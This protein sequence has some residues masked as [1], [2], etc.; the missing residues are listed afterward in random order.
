MAMVSAW[1][2]QQIDGMV[3]NFQ[4]FL[5]IDQRIQSAWRFPRR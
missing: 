2:V 4:S 3:D 5:T 1:L